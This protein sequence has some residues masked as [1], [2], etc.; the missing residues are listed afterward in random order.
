MILLTSAAYI[1]EE[2][3]VEFGKLPP[4]FL[5]LGGQKLFQ[6]QI[7]LL[8]KLQK[9]DEKI[10]ISLPQDFLVPDVDKNFFQ[11]HRVEVLTVPSKISLAESVYRC[12]E[13]LK[14]SERLLIL[15]GDTLFT[16]LPQADSGNYF[17][18]QLK[19]DA[20][21]RGYVKSSRPYGNQ[22][23][24]TGL[25]VF[26]NSETLQR[27]LK[28]MNFEAA[29]NEYYTQ[30][31]TSGTIEDSW[32]D[33]GHLNSYFQSRTKFTTQ[34]YFN[35]LKIEN[36]FVI[37]SSANREKIL[38]EARWFECLPH[39][40]KIRTPRYFWLKDENERASYCLEY[41]QYI[42]ISELYIFGRLKPQQWTD[43]LNDI[44]NILEE[45]QKVP[46][47]QKF[48]LSR[49]VSEKTHIR[50]KEF[51][52]N[53]GASLSGFE[54]GRPSLSFL[55]DKYSKLLETQSDIHSFWHGD[56][57]LSNLLYD[58]R[59]NRVFMIDPRGIGNT[60]CFTAFGDL[61]YDLAKLMHSF[62]GL[63]DHIIF[64]QIRY[65]LSSQFVLDDSIKNIQRQ[66]LQMLE[67]KF[68][69]L[70]RPL[71]VIMIHLF[72]SMLTLHTDKSEKL[73][74]LIENIYRLDGLYEEGMN[75][76]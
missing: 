26:D 72:I 47:E 55:A 51:T 17:S 35:D 12:V 21:K 54:R 29:I 27:L 39:E 30:A 48:K 19:D 76:L 11:T 45:F 16:S 31:K 38:A 4:A 56:F 65:E 10:F 60:G 28:V 74:L 63:Y 43:I 73:S 37:K 58:N 1:Q 9:D 44:F 49:F 70:Q 62:V 20:Y 40:L 71:F 66:F 69:G 46:V 57:C 67:K 68:P 3:Q 33:F 2:M 53:V 25:F 59:L 7:T 24:F 32:L 18:I 75:S 42:S 41:L 36:G 5:P 22:A 50:L 61:K 15:H 14:S 52:R 13:K 8:K 64:G 23:F 34:R 6:H